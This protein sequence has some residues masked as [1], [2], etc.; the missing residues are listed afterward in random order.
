MIKPENGGAYCRP[1]PTGQV[2]RDPLDVHGVLHKQAEDQAQEKLEVDDLRRPE[3]R[4]AGQRLLHADC[5]S[6]GS[7]SIPRTPRGIWASKLEL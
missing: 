1:S 2:D 6:W 7:L 4:A 3:V 5:R